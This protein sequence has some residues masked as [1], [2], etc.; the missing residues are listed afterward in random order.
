M[1]NR[2]SKNRTAPRKTQFMD[3][4]AKTREVVLEQETKAIVWRRISHPIEALWR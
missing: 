3:V 4:G 1:N 2:I